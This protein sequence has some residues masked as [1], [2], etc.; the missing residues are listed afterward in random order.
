MEAY[1]EHRTDEMHY[2]HLCEEI[3]YKKIPGKQIGNKWF[4][5]DCLKKMKE[6][7]DTIDEWEEEMAL[8]EEMQGQLDENLGL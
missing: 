5:I 8:G 3:I 6:V 4:C 2:C 7:L 1:A